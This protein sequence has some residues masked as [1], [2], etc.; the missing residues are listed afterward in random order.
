MNVCSR[1]LLVIAT[2]LS[3]RANAESW[4]TPYHVDPEEFIAIKQ[5]ESFDEVKRAIGRSLRHLFTVS[6]DGEQW[7]LGS[8]LIN[9][10]WKSAGLR[11]G[12]LFKDGT[13]YKL[14]DYKSNIEFDKKPGQWHVID[15]KRVPLFYEMCPWGVDDRRYVEQVINAPKLDEGAFWLKVNARRKADGF[16]LR[17][18]LPLTLLI[19]PFGVIEYPRTIKYRGIHAKADE[20]LSGF[21]IPLGQQISEC[22]WL[23]NYSLKKMMIDGK[24][25]RKYSLEDG[26]GFLRPYESARFLLVIVA[27]GIVDAVYNEDSYG[28]GFISPSWISGMTESKDCE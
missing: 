5:G 24:E 4:Y 22:L 25:V 20:N 17:G 8:V 9:T 1:F 28:N 3:L 12:I 10:G 7:K 27:D 26:K 11:Y 6:M 14:V 19:A 16:S 21:K 23:R 18:S 15:G 2:I 13:V